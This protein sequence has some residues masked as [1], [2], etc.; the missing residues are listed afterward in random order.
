MVDST[1]FVIDDDEAVRDALCELFASENIPVRA[2]A[3]AEEFLASDA[4]GSP[5]CLILDLMMPGMSGVDLQAELVRR[6][7]T[8][9]IIIMTGQGDVPKAVT[10]LK[11]GAFDFIEK[12][13]D[14]TALLK[15]VNQALNREGRLRRRYAEREAVESRL[16]LLSPRER[17]VMD[18]VVAG[19]SNKVIGTKLG[20]SVRTVENHRAK[21]M[22]KM[23]CNNV[24]SLITTILQIKSPAA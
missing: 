7:S 9:P 12:P 1:V 24:S 3:S 15:V 8:I 14:P 11:A 4:V 5:G 20:I 18:L 6:G 22:D 16:A 2:F 19:H 13:F 10:T 21:L 23:R 17:Q